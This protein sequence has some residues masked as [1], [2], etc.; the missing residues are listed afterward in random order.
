[1]N[2][3]TSPD[4]ELIPER[5]AIVLCQ[6]L[7]RTFL[8]SVSERYDVRVCLR[9]FTVRIGQFIFCCYSEF[10]ALQKDRQ[11]DVGPAFPLLFLVVRNSL[12]AFS[13]QSFFFFCFCYS[14]FFFF[15]PIISLIFF[16]FFVSVFMCADI[17]HIL[18]MI[19]F[20]F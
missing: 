19:L 10:F 9:K 1:M 11:V 5:A 14:N 16:Y 13:F 17:F 3:Q 18:Y 15:F 2:L 7:S 8:F 12:G 6:R 4:E 20:Y